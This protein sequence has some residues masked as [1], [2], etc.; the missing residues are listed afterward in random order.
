MFVV[1]YFDVYFQYHPCHI[2]VVHLQKDKI[3]PMTEATYDRYD[4]SYKLGSRLRMTLFGA[5]SQSSL[6]LSILM[7]QCSK[8]SISYGTSED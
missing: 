3:T 7:L 4:R 2:V 6:H 1:A 5:I 8:C